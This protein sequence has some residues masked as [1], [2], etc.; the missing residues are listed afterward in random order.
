MG[1]MHTDVNTT[2]RRNK[3]GCYKQFLL[4]FWLSLAN[5]LR[6][7]VLHIHKARTT[8]YRPSAYGQVERFNRTLM[9]TVRC[10]IGKTQEKWDQNIQ[11]ITM[12]I[13]ASV[14][15]STGYTPKMLMLDREISTPAQL[16]FPRINIAHEGY[17]EYVS[18][19]VQNI[20]KAHIT[21][22]TP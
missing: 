6:S 5:L 4:A 2:S 16:M 12:A 17:G 21:A 11:Q 19:L 8:P 3:Y 9:D 20:Q 10:F 14:N 1:R 15:R 13:R 18:Y 7:G 22:R